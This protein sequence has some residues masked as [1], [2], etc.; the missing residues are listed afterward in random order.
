[1]RSPDSGDIS[2][3]DFKRQQELRL[4]FDPTDEGYPAWASN[5]RIIFASSGGTSTT[6]YSRAVDGSGSAEVLSTSQAYRAPQSITRDGSALIVREGRNGPGV[7]LVLLPLRPPGPAR[8]LVATPAEEVGA[9]LS[10]DGRWLAY[11]TSTSGPSEVI[12]RPFP[13]VEDGYW[14]VSTGGGRMP[15]W[16]RDGREL[17]YVGPDD[18]LMSIGVDAGKSFQFS[19]TKAGARRSLLLSGRTEQP[20]LRHLSGRSAVPDDQDRDRG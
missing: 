7:D 3:W 4:T 15:M 6:L 13:T 2:V 1:M 12:V 5:D 8:P 11:Q 17:F 20:H 19:A 16:S 9:E 10:P 18:T 14:Q